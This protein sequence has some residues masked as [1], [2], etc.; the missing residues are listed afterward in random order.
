MYDPFDDVEAVDAYVDKYYQD[1]E[2]F[3]EEKFDSNPLSK[4]FVDY[5]YDNELDFI[6]F[7]DNFNRD[8]IEYLD[9]LQFDAQD[10]K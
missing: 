1:F 9:E 6:V 7:A 2:Y 3:C 5:C 4:Y 10:D 8:R